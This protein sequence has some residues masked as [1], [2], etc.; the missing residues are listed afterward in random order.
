ME[1]SNCF[2]HKASR[3]IANDLW[4][5]GRQNWQ[6]ISCWEQKEH[7]DNQQCFGT[8]IQL[9]ISFYMQQINC[10]KSVPTIYSIY[11]FV[12]HDNYASGRRSFMHWQ[13]ILNNLR[14]FMKRL[15]LT[16]A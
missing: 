14:F 7:T 12:F 3:P 8:L 15:R 9:C 11:F 10:H 16:F 13:D 6:P 4:G 5:D 2:Q 1:K